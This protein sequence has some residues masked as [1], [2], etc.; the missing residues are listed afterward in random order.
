METTTTATPTIEKNILSI[1][2]ITA[3]QKATYRDLMTLAKRG[4]D[5]WK[6]ALTKIAVKEGWNERDL[7]DIE[8]L[9][10]GIHANKGTDPITVDVLKDG[11]AIIID[12]ERRYTAYIWLKN[13]GYTDEW[14]DYMLVFIA[15]NEM[16]T[17]DRRVKQLT[18]NNSKD[19]EPYEE[20]MKFKKLADEGLSQAEIARRVGT[21]RMHVNNRLIYATITSVE[22]TFIEDKTIS[23]TEWVKLAKAVDDPMRRVDFILAAAKKGDPSAVEQDLDT[24]LTGA[25]PKEETQVSNESAAETQSDPAERTPPEVQMESNVDGLL[26]KPN[27]DIFDDEEKAYTPTTPKGLAALLNNTGIPGVE[28][29]ASTIPAVEPEPKKKPARLTREEI[30]NADVGSTLGDQ[31]PETGTVKETLHAIAIE[32]KGLDRLIK[33]DSKMSD[34]SFRIEKKIRYLQRIAN[35]SLLGHLTGDKATGS[36]QE[37]IF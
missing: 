35:N 4:K 26:K 33:G 34:I 9:A 36:D 22:Q 19:F 32:L 18:A 2:E 37:P 20:A 1:G 27:D 31:T 14:L 6:W 8:A 17:I 10:L 7:G 28:Q 21:N 13:N 30:L 24:A 11:K 12:G 25:K 16:T 29:V 23:V 15:S 3:D 5:T